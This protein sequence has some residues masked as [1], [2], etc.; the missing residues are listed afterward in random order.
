MTL[1]KPGLLTTTLL[2]TTRFGLLEAHRAT[3]FVLGFTSGRWKRSPEEEEE[4]K[5]GHASRHEVSSRE[6][7]RPGM[8]RTAITAVAR[9]CY[10]AFGQTKLVEDTFGVARE[11]ETRG[12]KSKRLGARRLMQRIMVPS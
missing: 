12:Q 11:E 4:E 5:E 9:G 10:A 3:Q 2:R 8:L 6:T 7:W 1:P